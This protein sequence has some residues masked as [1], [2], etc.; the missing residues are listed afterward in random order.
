MVTDQQQQQ[1]RSAVVVVAVVIRFQM[2]TKVLL[3][4]L[5]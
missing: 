3:V 1:L 5:V 4:A 2:E